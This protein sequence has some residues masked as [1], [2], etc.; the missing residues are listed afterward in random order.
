M[1]EIK[2]P[3]DLLMAAMRV[4]ER[5]RARNQQRRLGPSAVGGC[6]RQ[7]YLRVN[8]YQE[9]NPTKKMAAWLGTAA[10]AQI[11]EGIRSLDPFGD[12]FLV[13]H[14]VKTDVISG[15][16][17]CFDRDRGSVIDWKTSKKATLGWLSKGHALG[18]SADRWPSL[19]NRWQVHLYGWMLTQNGETVNDVSLVGIAKD[20]DEDHV[21]VFTE[22]Y[23]ESF[24]LRAL[25]WIQEIGELQDAPDPEK[26]VSFCRSYCG[27]WSESGGV[28]N[29]VSNDRIY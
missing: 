11:A 3:Q 26:S 20:G 6:R 10:H 16:V 4:K 13:E 15:T 21:R 8:G 22:P 29:G 1:D 27:F 17:D 14:A 25:A 2:D 28:C 9:T 24:A 5:G 7:A 19:E 12:R 18:K 23:E